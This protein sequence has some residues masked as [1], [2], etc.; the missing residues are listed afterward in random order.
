MDIGHYEA[1]A[2]M[3]LS[4]FALSEAKNMSLDFVIWFKFWAPA[5]LDSLWDFLVWPSFFHFLISVSIL[6]A[7]SAQRS[8][9]ACYY[10]AQ[11]N[12]N[13]I[14]PQPPVPVTESTLNSTSSSVVSKSLGVFGIL[15]VQSAAACRNWSSAFASL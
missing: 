1:N 8:G 12:V 13:Q 6:P 14:P 9:M 11:A 7:S 10:I 2:C 3:S 15:F 5:A 4:S